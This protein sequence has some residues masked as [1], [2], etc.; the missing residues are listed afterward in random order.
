M[1]SHICSWCHCLWKANLQLL[2]FCFLRITFNITFTTEPSGDLINRKLSCPP[3]TFQST[4]DL[5]FN[6]SWHL[7]PSIVAIWTHVSYLL[8][9]A[10]SSVRAIFNLHGPYRSVQF[11]LLSIHSEESE[12]MYLFRLLHL[13]LLF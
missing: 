3:L 10:L 11:L 2:L 5:L 9:W 4:L 8:D 12:W 1:L 13:M 6:G 7:D